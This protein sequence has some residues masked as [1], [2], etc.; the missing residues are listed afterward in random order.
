MKSFCRETSIVLA[1]L[2]VLTGMAIAQAATP[3]AQ[4]SVKQGQKLNNEG[5]QDEALKLYLRPGEDSQL[6]RRPSGVWRGLGPEGRLRGRTRTLEESDRSGSSGPEESRAASNGLFLCLRGQI[7]ARRRNTRSR[8]L[9][10]LDGEAGLR[11][12]S[13]RRE[14]VGAY[15]A[16][17]GRY[18]RRGEMVQDRLRHRDAQDRT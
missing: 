10:R 16:G 8:C 12:G 4:A 18:R 2:V 13:R 11:G 1:I 9:T 17:V 7:G 15:Q 14:R 5:K 3:D 6:L